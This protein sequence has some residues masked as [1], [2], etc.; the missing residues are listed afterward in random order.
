[1]SPLALSIV[2][3]LLVFGGIFFGAV[4]R[5]V[6][7]GHHVSKETQ[8]V[9]RLGAGL[10]A[11]LAALVLGLLISASKASFDSKSTQIKQITAN[12]ILLDNLLAQY[13]AEAMPLRKAM[14]DAISP[15][16]DRVWH[17]KAT[18]GPFAATSEGER[19]YLGL[20]AL[21]PQN[22]TQQ[23]LKARALQVSADLA[24]TRLLLFVEADNAIPVPFLAILVL[25]LVVIFATFSLFSDLNATALTFLCV[26][27][28]SASCAIYLILE[29]NQPFE[30][31][32][33]I[34]EA[35][36]RNALTPLT[37]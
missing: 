1:M 29:L 4:F 31:L 7:P 24:Q 12:L 6:L 37:Q 16:V 28:L 8:D 21:S 35:P 33:M 19:L 18:R 10:I 11:T 27:A 17:E 34:S 30:G 36:L 22:E 32:M 20:Y 5:R 2:I 9:V 3:F 23:S 13:G 14:R 25:W 15:F 26:F